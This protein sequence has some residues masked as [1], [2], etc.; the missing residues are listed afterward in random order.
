MRESGAELGSNTKRCRSSLFRLRS[1]R[2]FKTESNQAGPADHH[3]CDWQDIQRIV[4]GHRTSA[5]RVRRQRWRGFRCP[6]ERNTAMVGGL[7]KFRVLEFARQYERTL[8][9]DA[10]VILRESAPDLF[11]LVPRGY[12]A[13]HDD[14]P[15]LPSYDWLWSERAAILGSQG[16][17]MDRMETAWNTGIVLCDRD[18]ADIWQHPLPRSCHRT[19]R[20]S[21][22]SRVARGSMRSFEYQP[23]S[24]P[25]TGCRDSTS[26][27]Q[28]QRSFTWQTVRIPSELS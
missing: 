16:R 22:G 23:S 25:S 13:M 26:F 19:V 15:H 17:P 18:Q 14:W 24:I 7:E 9:I 27:C 20:N 11:E 8:Y 2:Q 12:V 4:G 1:G 21:S 28:L 3:H 10:D 6:Y 5:R